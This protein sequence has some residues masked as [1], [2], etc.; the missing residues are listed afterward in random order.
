MLRAR[1]RHG[2]RFHGSAECRR[3]EGAPTLRRERR[4]LLHRSLASSRT[5]C[6][7][8]RSMSQGAWTD[9]SRPGRHDGVRRSLARAGSAGAARTEHRN[10]TAGDSAAEVIRGVGLDLAVRTDEAAR[11]VGVVAQDPGLA[12]PDVRDLRLAGRGL[13]DGPRDARLPLPPE[14][15]GGARRRRDARAVGPAQRLRAIAVHVLATAPLRLEA[16]ECVPRAALLEDALRA[17]GRDDAEKQGEG[18]RRDQDLLRASHVAP[19]S[20]AWVVLWS[21]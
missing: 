7:P 13:L 10:G 5:S 6:R 16:L 19:R 1:R 15:G 2:H 14:D 12:V 17:G 9:E 4:T 8:R 18:E 11:P 20:T 3:N 21:R